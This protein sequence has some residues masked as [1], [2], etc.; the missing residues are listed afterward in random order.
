MNSRYDISLMVKVADMY[1]NSGLKQEEIAKELHISRSSI[2]MILTEAKEH[3]IVEINIR[4]PLLNNDE[5]SQQFEL[6]FNVK[7]C[8]I[9]PTKI[10]DSDILTKLAG[11]RMAQVFSEEVEDYNTVGIAWGRT[12]YECM[13]SYKPVKKLTGVNIVPLVGATDRV[14]RRYQLNEMVRIFASKVDGTPTFIYAPAIP[15]LKKDKDLYMKSSLM[16]ELLQKWRSIDIALIGVGSPPRSSGQNLAEEK[17]GLNIA[18]AGIPIGDI[19]ARH[20]DKDGCFIKDEFSERVIGIS[21]EDLSNA[22]KVICAA[23]GM[24]KSVSILGALKTDIIDIFISDEQT[25]KEVLRVK[26]TQT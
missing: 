5:L 12:L 16:Q 25:A 21:P 14:Q 19:L 17:N 11:E 1:Y 3:G 15:A 23:S 4:N 8:Y 2:S 10:Q 22:K 18:E 26:S 6:T 7:K 13:S 24:E 9:I 20:F